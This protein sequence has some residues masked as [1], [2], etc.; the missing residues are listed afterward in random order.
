MAVVEHFEF[1]F[2]VFGDNSDS[3]VRIIGVHI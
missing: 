3:L 2:V 1:G